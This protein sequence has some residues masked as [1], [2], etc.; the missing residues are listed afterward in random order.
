MSGARRRPTYRDHAPCQSCHRALGSHG[1][2]GAP[3]RVAEES[4]A[5]VSLPA[6]RSD[7]LTVHLATGPQRRLSSRDDSGPLS[8]IAPT[9]RARAHDHHRKGADQP[10]VRAFGFLRQPRDGVGPDAA[11]VSASGLL[12]HRLDRDLDLDLV[13][14][15]HAPTLDGTIPLHAVIEPVHRRGRLEAKAL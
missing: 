2:A 9:R 4:E 3:V 5:R 12:P 10:L 14:E 13:A 8:L 6:V 15:H 7:N 11:T 1:V